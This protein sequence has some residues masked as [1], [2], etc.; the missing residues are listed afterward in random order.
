MFHYFCT[1]FTVF[2]VSL[3]GEGHKRGFRIFASLHIEKVVISVAI[4]VVIC[5]F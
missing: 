3:F 5:G 4:R 2:V 1:V